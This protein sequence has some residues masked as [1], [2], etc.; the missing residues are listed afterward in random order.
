M[1]KLF[2]AIRAGDLNEVAAIITKN[3]ET[4]SCVA[5]PPPKKDMGQSPL[6]V[7]VKTAQFDIAYYLIEQGADCDFMESEE[8][9]S[10]WRTPVLHDAIRIVLQSLCYGQTDVSEKGLTLVKTLLENGADPA[11][12]ASNG[13]AALDHTVCE[14]ENIL[15][16]QS[17]YPNVQELCEER[18]EALLDILLEH[19]ADFNAWANRGH[20]PEPTPGEPNRVRYIDDFVPQ[21]DVTQ[22]YTIRGREYTSVIKGNV[23]KTAHTRAVI[24]KYCRKHGL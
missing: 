19:G 22:T 23:D 16:R 11:K 20:Y 1:K 15:E 3:P 12:P 18:L 24:Q 5:T 13:F 17:A 14:A 6:Q 8:E 7:A 21:E 4:I 10:S 9:G 2:K